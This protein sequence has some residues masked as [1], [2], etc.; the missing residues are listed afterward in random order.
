MIKMIKMIVYKI[1]KLELTLLLE[2]RSVL[3]LRYI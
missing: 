3:N 2:L 1:V